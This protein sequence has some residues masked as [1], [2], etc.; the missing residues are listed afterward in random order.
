M[1]HWQAEIAMGEMKESELGRQREEPTPPSL[2]T[3]F[4]YPPKD[5]GLRFLAPKHTSRLLFP[6]EVPHST[7]RL[8]DRAEASWGQRTSVHP[9][10]P[11]HDISHSGHLCWRRVCTWMCGIACVQ[12]KNV[13]SARK[14]TQD[15]CS[16]IFLSVHV[17]NWE[18][19]LI[20]PPGGRC[21]G[22]LMRARKT[23]NESWSPMLQDHYPGYPA[24]D[25]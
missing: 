2:P 6:S 25:G 1:F 17:W 3:L 10:Q 18:C 19:F 11:L 8:G 13:Y 14:E 5:S 21:Q 16:C 20:F 12:K 24:N 9:T 22:S 4:L 23:Q 7:E 15:V